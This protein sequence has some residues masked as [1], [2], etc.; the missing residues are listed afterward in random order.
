MILV[1]SCGC[2]TDHEKLSNCKVAPHA[3]DLLEA[4]DNLLAAHSQETFI[5]G[6]KECT[7]NCNCPD[8]ENARQ[9]IAKARLEY[10]AESNG[11]KPE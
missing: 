1:L 6:D 11:A 10:E 3:H 9:A 7:L 5:D 4:L 8:C 2:V